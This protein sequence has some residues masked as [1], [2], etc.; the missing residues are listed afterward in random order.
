MKAVLLS[1]GRGTRLRP[2]THTNNKHA[3]PIANQPLLLYPFLSIVDAG[4]KQIAVIVNETRSEIEAI[5]GNGSKWGVKVTY[6]F[7]AHPGGLAHAM[8]LAEKFVGKSKFVLVLGD[9]I[10]QMGFKKIAN[11]F[12]KSKEE[13]HLL[14]VK[15][16][17]DQHKRLGMATTDAEGKVLRYIEK[18]GVVDKSKLYDPKRSYGVTGFYFFNYTVFKCFHGKGKIKPSI[19]GEYEI[20]SP[21]NW[22]I[23]HGLKNIGLTEVSGWWKDPGNPEDMLAVNRL[24]LSWKQKFT[25]PKRM[26]LTGSKLD[27]KIQ[28]GKGCKISKSSLR[29]PVVIGDDV[30]LHNCYI[31]PYTSIGNGVRIENVSIENSIIM[32][33]SYLYDVESRLDS[34]MIGHGVEITEQKENPRA[35]SLFV[36]DDSKIIL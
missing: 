7:Q 32:S 19:R 25:Q 3:L 28:I 16:P 31:G 27:E 8:S 22:L 5:L 11:D 23:E 2:L 15:V 29:G 21:Y 34:C 1:G 35:S 13:G 33:G 4:I 14:G 20:A 26:K 30:E 10:L 12:E 17:L 6:I 24:V 9:N 36:G 18:P